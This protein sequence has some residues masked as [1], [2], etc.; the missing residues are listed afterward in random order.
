VSAAYIIPDMM[1]HIT[2]DKYH[3]ESYKDATAAMKEVYNRFG[4][5]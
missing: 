3:G 2:V 5:K 4:S 1:V